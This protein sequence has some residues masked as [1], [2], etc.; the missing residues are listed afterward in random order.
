MLLKNGM[1]RLIS[2]VSF[3]KKLCRMSFLVRDGRS[4]FTVDVGDLSDEFLRSGDKLLMIS[5]S[6]CIHG[7]DTHFE[8]ER[9]SLLSLASRGSM[10]SISVSG[11]GASCGGVDFT[12]AKIG[13]TFS[14]RLRNSL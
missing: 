4:E 13:S 8:L 5:L 11:L 9:Y 1:R 12:A 6:V 14:C 10:C 7:S 3:L 2:I